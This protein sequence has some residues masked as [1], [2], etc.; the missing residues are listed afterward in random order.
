MDAQKPFAYDEI[1]YESQAIARTNPATIAAAARMFGL[2]AA[3]AS[4]ARVLEVGCA[5]GHNIFGLATAYPQ[6]QFLGIDLSAVQIEQGNKLLA[7]VQLE[8]VEL[9][10]LDILDIDS[11]IGTFDYIIC[12]GI[13]SW[14]PLPV[15]EKI[16]E[17]FRSHLNP[18]GVAYVSYNSYPGWHVRET[19]RGMMLFHASNFADSPTKIKAAR[20]F[21]QVFLKSLEGNNPYGPEFA[22]ELGVISQMPD[23]YLFHDFLSEVNQPFYFSEILKNFQDA[24]LQYLCD[25]EIP[26]LFPQE[27]PELSQQVLKSVPGGRLLKEQYTDFMRRTMFKRSLLVQ[28]EAALSLQLNAERIEELSLRSSLRA[29]V[30]G[31]INLEEGVEVAFV[32]P[33]GGKIV[34]KDSLSKAAFSML[35]EQKSRYVG[36]QEVFSVALA[37]TGKPETAE[38]KSELQGVFLRCYLAGLLSLAY[39]DSVTSEES[40]MSQ[41]MVSKLVRAEVETGG[42]V[43]NVFNEPVALSDMERL[44]V[45]LLDGS[46][47]NALLLQELK[48]KSEFTKIV[49]EENS[50]EEMLLDATLA[51]LQSHGLL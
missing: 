46:R 9:R 48:E 19:I 13:Y 10:Q 42:L 39:L 45:S 20:Q 16:L 50:S 29:T 1:P 28:K 11:S 47:T 51:R 15:R 33:G 36:F 22:K 17:V 6:A 3:S 35:A 23:W 32:S 43:T 26:K 37:T 38:I 14:V 40:D 31:D 7:K 41:P 30:E 44:L 2:P 25:A 34:L 27:L 21:L 5:N 12:H 8:N 18:H 49:Q 4:S 24:G